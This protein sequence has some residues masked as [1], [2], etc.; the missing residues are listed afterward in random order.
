MPM[1][2]LLEYSDNYSKTSG[3]LWSYY[4]DEVND[5]ASET[6]AGSYR[7]DDNKTIKCEPFGY[8]TNKTGSAP[9]DNNT[10]DKRAVAPLKHLSNFWRSLDMFLIKSEIKIDLS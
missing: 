3:R 9:A 10:L 4:R 7:M 8:K 5:D 2:N 6:D 1:Y